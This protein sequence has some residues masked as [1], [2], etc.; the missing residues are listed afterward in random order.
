MPLRFL[1][2]P[3]P[4]LKLVV[5]ISKH[6]L[7]HEIATPVYALVRND[8][9]QNDIGHTPSLPQNGYPVV[10]KIISQQVL[11]VNFTFSCFCDIVCADVIG[12]CVFYETE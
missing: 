10:G 8:N 9:G 5:G 7:F 4:V 6:S 3:R 11:P 1:V 2:I 12:R